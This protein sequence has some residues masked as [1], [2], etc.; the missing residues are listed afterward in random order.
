MSN[1]TTSSTVSQTQQLP[2]LF[3]SVKLYAQIQVAKVSARYCIKQLNHP[4]VY[5]S[6]F[7]YILAVYF[8]YYQVCLLFVGVATTC[9]NA[10]HRCEATLSK[11]YKSTKALRGLMPTVPDAGCEVVTGTADDL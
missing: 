1:D 8:K 5:V 3:G 9:H 11:V 10:F 4:E 7:L 6:L 2:E